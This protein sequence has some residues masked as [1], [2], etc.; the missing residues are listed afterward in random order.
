MWNDYSLFQSRTQDIPGSLVSSHKAIVLC[1]SDSQL[2][3][4]F[5]RLLLRYGDTK[6]AKGVLQT[7]RDMHDL[8]REAELAELQA[9][10]D[11]LTAAQHRK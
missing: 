9:D 7:L 8:R 2:Q 3:A 11:R 5:A 6:D 1:P 10:Y 4:N